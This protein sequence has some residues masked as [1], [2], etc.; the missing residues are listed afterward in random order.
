M[1]KKES[2]TDLATLIDKEI[3]VKLSGGRESI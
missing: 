3:R 2:A 1:S